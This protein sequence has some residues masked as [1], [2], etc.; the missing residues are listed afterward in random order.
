MTRLLTA[1]IAATAIGAAAPASA[2]SIQLDFPTLT[3][4]TQPSPDVGQ[5]C[6]DLTLPMGDTCATTK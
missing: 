5:A 1:L 2:L 3:Y 4:P 6:S